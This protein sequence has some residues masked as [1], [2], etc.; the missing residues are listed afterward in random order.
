[1]KL[2][3]AAIRRTVKNRFLSDF[4]FVCLLLHLGYGQFDS[5]EDCCFEV[6]SVECV[7]LED[8]SGWP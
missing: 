8:G 4:S 2:V 6:T 7:M 3:G 1:M 5:C